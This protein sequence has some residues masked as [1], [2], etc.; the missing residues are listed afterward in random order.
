MS[1]M[2]LNDCAVTVMDSDV[3]STES[4]FVLETSESELE[5]DNSNDSNKKMLCKN[6]TNKR[7]RAELSTFCDQTTIVAKKISK[8][9]GYSTDFDE[10]VYIYFPFQ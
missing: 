6:K 2:S 3:G 7:P 1:R 4:D 5:E 8:C 9:D 10:N